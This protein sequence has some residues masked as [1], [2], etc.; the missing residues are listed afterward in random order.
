MSHGSEPSDRQGGTWRDVENAVGL[1]RKSSRHATCKGAQGH[2]LEPRAF[3]FRPPEPT[4]GMTSRG[5]DRN[6]DLLSLFNAG[7]RARDGFMLWSRSCSY[8]RP[9]ETAK[10]MIGFHVSKLRGRAD[11]RLPPRSALCLDGLTVQVGLLLSRIRVR[12]R[13]RGDLKKGSGRVE[14]EDSSS[15]NRRIPVG[16]KMG[17]IGR[18]AVQVAGEER[19]EE[20]QDS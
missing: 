16:D 12:D 4:G 17:W 15:S 6:G 13:S 18:T 2:N 1:Q 9:K 10:A 5:L 20:K 14:M 7:E 19:G 3:K 8:S 11:N